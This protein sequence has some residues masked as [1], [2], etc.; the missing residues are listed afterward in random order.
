MEKKVT[1]SLPM[2]LLEEID[3]AISGKPLTLDDFIEKAIYRYFA[4][5]KF[6][7]DTAGFEERDQITEAIDRLGRWIKDTRRKHEAYGA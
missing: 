2:E 6:R 7:R 4:E 1:I 5:E 3:T